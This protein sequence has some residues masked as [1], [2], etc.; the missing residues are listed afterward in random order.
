LFQTQAEINFSEAMERAGPLLD[1]GEKDR[2]AITPPPVRPEGWGI[3]ERMA[4]GYTAR[5][6]FNDADLSEVSRYRTKF[7]EAGP[8]RFKARDAAG[9]R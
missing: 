5:D 6:K 8:D 7:N 4:P 3:P 2:Y 1:P 9:G